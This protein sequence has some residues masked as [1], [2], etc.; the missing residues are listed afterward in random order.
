[1]P[2]D[3]LP[4]AL[5][6]YRG[7]VADSFGPSD[8][9]DAVRRLTDPGCARETLHWG[10]NYLYTVEVETNRGRLEVVVK[11]FRNQGLLAQ[12]KRRRFGSKAEK[13]WRS[14]WALVA[15]GIETP[16]PLMLIESVSVNGPSFFVSSRLEDFFESRF[17]F[18]ALKEG[19]ETELFPEVDKDELLRLLASICRRLHQAGI[20]HRDISIGNLLLRL[21]G[22]PARPVV[23]LTDLNRARRGER[24]GL[25]RRTRD[26]C[27]LPIPTATDRSSF[28][29]AYWGR[30]VSR[31]SLAYALFW[32]QQEAFLLKNRLKAGVRRPF[33]ALRDRVIPRRAHAHIPEAPKG[34]SV[35][36][37]IVWDRLSDQP[38]QHATR[39]ERWKVRL[40][41]LG[42]HREALQAALAST[43]ETWRRYR[44]L[45]GMLYQDEV[46]WGVVGVAVRPRPEDPEGLLTV[47][48]ESGAR[49][50]L[51]RLHPWAEN[52]DPEEELAHELRSRG[53]E[54]TFALPQNRDL[55]RDPERWRSA[56][57]E[58]A[59]RFVPLGR[60]FQVGQ[61]I[62]RSKWGI[63][64]YR[65]YLDLVRTAAEILRRRGEVQILGPAV[66]D[67][68]F[69]ATA[70]VVNMRREGVHFDILSSLL[71]VDRRGAPENRQLGFDSAGKA[72]LLKAIADSGRN[73]SDRCW[74]TEVNWPLWEGPH[75]PA[76]KKVS[77]DEGTQADYLVR[78][79][80]L[81][82][83]TGSVERVYWWRLIAR[84]YG[85]VD[86]LGEEGLRYRPSFRALLHLQ[87][88]LEGA[89]FIRP[90]DS[91]KGVR[92][93]LFRQA[94]GEEL[95]V[96]WS[97]VGERRVTFE[98]P[99]VQA[100][101][102]DG[103]DL[104][105]TP[106]RETVVCSGPRYYRLERL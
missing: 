44:R 34:V 32:I 76:G 6:D 101:D 105:L 77:V 9:E 103:R 96:G 39:A 63:W 51:L 31:S 84:G 78:F 35:R 68:E 26:L 98:R 2:A 55:V 62:N 91:E 36:D 61:A 3:R 71:Y 4:F 90:L 92:L 89:T 100:W 67:F 73:C 102:R 87:R 48:A 28:L 74:I 22:E 57:E 104:G 85:L 41:D 52:H 8:L 83:A 95:V 18:R 24:L 70:A 58:L 64:N 14:A 80:L 59:E 53:Y 94:E 46:R 79:C 93:Y 88:Q 38:H 42:A 60:H 11:Q 12:L 1:M 5:A 75:S 29:S 66:I 21:E 99:L 106:L 49:H 72:L 65:E 27:R 47:L 15:A 40:A 17:Y 82:L 10:R 86:P 25:W 23:Y 81:V 54:I 56:I 13:S 7:E 97:A 30:E 16:Q 19:R 43:P 50:V 45:K 37:K 20:R 33:R 69:H